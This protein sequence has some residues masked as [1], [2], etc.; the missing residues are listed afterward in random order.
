M[1]K[2]VFVRHGGRCFISTTFVIC[3]GFDMDFRHNGESA[4]LIR[5]TYF[6]AKFEPSYEK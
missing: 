3:H 1:I 4:P 2:P 6:G 5:S